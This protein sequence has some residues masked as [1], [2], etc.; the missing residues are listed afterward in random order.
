MLQE[1]CHQKVNMHFDVLRRSYSISPREGYSKNQRYSPAS[2]AIDFWRK[3]ILTKISC[4][5]EGL[6]HSRE[7]SVVLHTN[8]V[9]IKEQSSFHYFFFFFPSFDFIDELS[10]FFF[11]N[12]FYLTTLYSCSFTLNSHTTEHNEPF[13]LPTALLPCFV[14]EHYCEHT[15]C[16]G[17]FD[18]NKHINSYPTLISMLIQPLHTW[19]QHRRSGPIVWIWSSICNFSMLHLSV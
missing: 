12:Y 9:Q 14:L 10:F 11:L 16:S 2:P 3:K 19:D 1:W 13:P 17:T 15:L 6:K 18:E 4:A 5:S 7:D 8:Q